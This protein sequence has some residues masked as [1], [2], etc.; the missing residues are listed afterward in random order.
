M[1][2]RKVTVAGRSPKPSE[3]VQFLPRLPWTRIRFCLRCRLQS[4]EALAIDCKCQF[5]SIERARSSAGSEQQISN[6]RVAGSSPAERA[7][8]TE[9]IGMGEK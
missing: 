4:A 9:T 8:S 2:V 6:L 1:K 7:S 5:A 3:Q